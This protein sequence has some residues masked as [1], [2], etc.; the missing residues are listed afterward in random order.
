MMRSPWLALL[1]TTACAAGQAASEGESITPGE[2]FRL[3]AGAEVRLPSAGLMVR[4]ASVVGDSRCPSDVTCIWEG[5][6][7]IELL[8]S[9][10]GEETSLRLH[11][12]GSGQY[13]RQAS[14][15]GVTLRLETLDPYPVSTAPPAAEDYVATLLLTE[16]ET[17]PGSQPAK[18]RG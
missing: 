9:T 6:A 17:D 11:T 4:F 1:L 7:E 12:Q 16:G 13:A 15:H 18:L 10:N 3:A 8:L 5:N 14:A 2:P